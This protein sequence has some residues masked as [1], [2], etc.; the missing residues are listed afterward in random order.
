MSKTIGWIFVI[1]V[2][3][4][5]IWWLAGNNKVPAP[6]TEEP[7]KIGVILPLTGDLAVVGEEVKSGMMIAEAEAQEAGV[8]LEII[9]EDDAFA[10]RL[11]TNAATKLINID[12]VDAVITGIIEEAKPIIPLF[13]ESGVPL[14][15]VW[16]S[17]EFLKTV[18]PTIYS[19]GFSTEKTGERMAEYAYQ[20]LGLGRIAILG[21][22]DTWAEV[23]TP[24]FQNK[25]ESL[26]GEVVLTEFL[27]IDT[28]D[29]RTSIAK[30]KQL[31]PDG[32][33]FPMVPPKSA[34]FLIQADQMG[35]EATLL[36]GD[37]L[38]QDVINE[39]GPAAE[40]IY[41]TN[42]Y[43]D[44]AAEI[45]AKYK[46]VHQ[47][48]PLDPALASFGYDGIQTLLEAWKKTGDMKS[49]LVEFF[50][51]TNFI[52]RIEK[53]FKVTNGQPVEVQ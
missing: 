40:G 10:P 21:H 30:I 48:D 33:Y 27:A 29:Y 3:V 12:K 1:L 49:G 23:I 46:K 7:I 25:F 5:G 31:K 47:R 20:Q 53:V 22:N 26:G 36:T 17:N 4:V 15:V 16:D 2:V 44:D 13:N 18:G 41:F 6:A 38:I 32:V 39:A 11:S 42:I 35:L 52:D 45:T 28:S 43:V 8:N 14:L 24:A 37:P 51:G 9:Y 19:I 50:G 34:Q